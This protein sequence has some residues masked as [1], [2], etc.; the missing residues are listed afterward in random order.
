LVWHPRIP[1]EKLFFGK[2]DLL[3]YQDHVA[4]SSPREDRF[5]SAL[6][7]LILVFL[8][9]HFKLN[10]FFGFQISPSA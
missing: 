3:V 8:P 6:D 2:G 7:N 1:L 5:T 4:T 9:D 10:S